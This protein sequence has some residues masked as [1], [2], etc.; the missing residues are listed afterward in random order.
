MRTNPGPTIEGKLTTNV[1][2]I[3]SFDKAGADGSE[4]KRCVARDEDGIHK[5][6]NICDCKVA[7][8][9]DILLFIALGLPYAGYAPLHMYIDA[10]V[11]HKC[12]CG[13]DAPHLTGRDDNGS[14]IE[15]C[16]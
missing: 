10:T 3:L 8:L 1:N 12:T 7:H 6:C 2:S 13:H 9:T 5:P 16:A 11:C 4:D 14:F 15:C